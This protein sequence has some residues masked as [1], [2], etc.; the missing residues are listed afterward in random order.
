MPDSPPRLIVTIDGPAGTGKSAVSQQLA[1]RLG[2][3]CLDTGAM[4]RCVSLLALRCGVDPADEVGLMRLIDT[5]TIDFDWQCYPPA[6]LLDKQPVE[7][8]IRTGDVGR[9]VSIVAAIAPVRTA[10]VERQRAIADVHPRLVS[11]GRDQGS[12]V[13]P[14]AEVRFFLTAD[15]E[16]RIQRR[17]RQLESRGR[18]VNVDAIRAEI[19]GRDTLDSTRAV[20]PLMCPVGAIEIDT[21]AVGLVGVVEQLEQ[22]VRS[23]VSNAILRPC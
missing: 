12:V 4:Y 10:M 5:H 16:I 14:D 22:A 19:E 17:V 3:D 1:E 2:L 6:I 23:C 20:G 18:K 11:E 7:G 9:V 13:F 15:P 21:S 8:E